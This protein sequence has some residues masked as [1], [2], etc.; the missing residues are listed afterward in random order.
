MTSENKYEFTG[1][2]KGGLKQIRRISDGV[3][4]GWIQSEYNLS[5]Y[6]NAWVYGYARVH[7]NARVYGYAQVY[8]NAWV[9]G[10]VRVYGYAQVY[11][12][13]WV[14]GNAQVHGV[15]DC[16]SVSGLEC[17]ITYTK[18]DRCLNI[19]C[20]RKTLEEWMQYDGNELPPHVI[21]FVVALAKGAGVWLK[22]DG[23]R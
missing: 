15:G 12:N 1:E 6:G 18:S 22:E 3:I 21:G 5:Q 20:Q 2:T 10:D 16:W 4:G 23:E 13:A 11:G 17:P 9:H 14:H 8:G 19:G 7:G